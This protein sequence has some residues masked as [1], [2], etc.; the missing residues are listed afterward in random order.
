MVND[1]VMV[2]VSPMKTFTEEPVSV[3]VAELATELND[4]LL[5]EPVLDV[6]G[7][8]SSG[9]RLD[10]AGLAA[11]DPLHHLAHMAVLRPVAHDG[12]A[13]GE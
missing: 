6:P 7:A 3:S 5:P 12:E 10:P 1:S 9:H 8:L 13:L 11:F 2:C 4:G